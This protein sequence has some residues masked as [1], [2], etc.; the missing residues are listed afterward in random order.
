MVGGAQQNRVTPSP[1]DFRL[2]ILDLDL[3]SDKKA[4]VKLKIWS[5]L[6][7]PKQISPLRW[8]SAES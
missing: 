5:N 8:C 2:W 6:L 7:K 1:F 3:D 4:V